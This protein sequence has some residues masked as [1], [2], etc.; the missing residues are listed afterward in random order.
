MVLRKGRISKEKLKEV[1]GLTSSINKDYIL[2]EYA[3]K[4]GADAALIITPYYNKPTQEGLYRH[5]KKIAEEVDIPICLYNVP[6]RT[7]INL[8]AG[9]V[10]RLSEIKNIRAVKEA[11]GDISQ[12]A[13]I[14]NLCGNDIT[15]LS[16]DD[17]ITYVIMALGG[18]G[19]VSVLAN[20]APEAVH[21]MTDSFLKG[22]T[23]SA[24]KIH[25]KWFPLILFLFLLYFS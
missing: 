15:L 1:M 12:C 4:T 2:A 25:N 13:K 6:S 18:K 8:E 22:D 10:K 19:V 17:S 20:I 14:V 23:A 7:G 5:Y 9:T 24:L 16:G 21:L 11:S 3:K